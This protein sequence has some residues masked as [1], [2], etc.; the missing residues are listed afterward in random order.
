VIHKFT[1]HTD[2]TTKQAWRTGRQPLYVLKDEKRICKIN[3]SQ[4]YLNVEF[5]FG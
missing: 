1:D 3:V 2:P 5:L 4:L